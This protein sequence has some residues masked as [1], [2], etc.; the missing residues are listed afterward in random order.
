M[1]RRLHRLFRLIRT[2][3]Y[4]K[5]EQFAGRARLLLARPRIDAAP[6]PPLRQAEGPW[7]A[8]PQR[9][10]SM[11]GPAHFRFLNH[12]RDLA[13]CGWDDPAEAKLWRYNL[14]Y[15]DDLG[16][17]G[18]AARTGWHQALIARWIAEN[19]PPVGTGWEAY[20]V[21]LRLINWIKWSIAGHNP[22]PEMLHS[23]AIQARWL[24]QR[25][26]WHLLGNHLFINAK[27]LF[28]AGHFF[29]GDEAKAWID[30]AVGIFN[31]ELDEQ[32]LADGAQF[33]LSPMYH[34]L[35]LEDL[36][37][38]IN[39]A[40]RYPAPLP[41]ALL[42]RLATKAAKA[43]YWMKAMDHGD[44]GISF[45]N[46]AAFDIAPTS[47]QLLD[48]LHALGLSDPPV[49]GGATW[50]AASGYA[51][52]AEGEA[53]LLADLAAIGPDYLPGHAHA[54]SL[55]FEF[56]LGRERIFVN[57]GTSVYGVGEERHRQRGTAAHN[58]VVVADANSSE[59][60]SGF[61]VGR[62][63]RIIAPKVAAAADQ[64]TAE[65]AH[66]GYRYLSGSPQHFRRFALAAKSLTIAD[67]VSGQHGAAVWLHLHPAVMAEPSAPNCFRLTTASGRRLT[68]TLVGG[69]S[70]VAPS[71]WHPRFGLAEP[72]QCLVLPLAAGRAETRLTWE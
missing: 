70:R 2:L 15:F 5:P 55:S 38:L 18:A 61:R 60:W 47:Q 51:R 37:D 26:E 48:Y 36:L 39:I 43:A 44:G 71:T 31:R 56:S 19:P 22:G 66:D 49:V 11:L 53:L 3:R 23:M 32:F 69:D 20:P 16:A 59:I 1:T 14:H 21:S 54:D 40:R 50:L 41:A 24:A 45:F 63:A 72:N 52:L 25:L 17:D 4:L 34:A 35:G 65:A 68:L 33:E 42:E 29:A 12:E 27:A 8:P 62:R 64:L 46:D 9:P 57:S 7:A 67:V 28:F 30:T 13:D 10:A 58:S 6:P